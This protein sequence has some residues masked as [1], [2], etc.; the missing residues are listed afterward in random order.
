ME[1]LSDEVRV[2]GSVRI[3]EQLHREPLSPH[4]GFFDWNPVGMRDGNGSRPT[5]LVV[6]ALQKIKVCTPSLLG[7]IGSTALARLK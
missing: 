1:T 7:F 6:P 2:G 4:R 5:R 3:I